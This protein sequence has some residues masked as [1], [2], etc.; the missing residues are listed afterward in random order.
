MMAVGAALFAGALSGTLLGRWAFKPTLR[1][2]AQGPETDGQ[3]SSAGGSWLLSPPLVA[4]V[5]APTYRVLPYAVVGAVADLA[6]TAA[7]WGA[8]LHPRRSAV[9]VARLVEAPSASIISPTEPLPT[10]PQQFAM[11]DFMGEEFFHNLSPAIEF[12]NLP[13]ERRGSDGVNVLGANWGGGF[14]SLTSSTSQTYRGLQGQW[15]QAPPSYGACQLFTK[16]GYLRSQESSLTDCP[17]LSSK[18]RE[19][20]EYRYK[21]GANSDEGAR[22]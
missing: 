3:A 11:F 8:V 13:T 22:W 16:L 17:S 9:P 6:S 19:A 14:E 12:H 10:K 5:L 1:A 15:I 7:A 18:Q 21:V 4:G 2:S 20:N